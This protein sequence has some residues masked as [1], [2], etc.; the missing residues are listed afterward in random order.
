[1]KWFRVWSDMANDP[2]WRTI[3]RVSGQRIGDVMAVYLH[4]LTL[5]SNAEERGLISGWNDEDIASALDIEAGQVTAIFEAMQGRVLDDMRLTG[6]EK[7]QPLREDSSTD[8]VRQYRQKKK[9][10]SLPVSEEPVTQNETDETQC[11]APVT[12]CNARV[13]KKRIDILSGK[14]DTAP[15]Q[16]EEKEVLAYLNQKT[17]RNYQPVKANLSL[18]TGRLKEGYST[19]DMILVIDDKC[20]AWLG[21]EKMREYLRPKTLF[22]ATNFS[23]YVA[24]TGQSPNP[25]KPWELP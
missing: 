25:K 1:M 17:G 9:Q 10:E 16:N 13:D 7:R 4:M 15:S 2:K 5:A 6:W 18:I 21:D 20:Q 23:Q 24:G 8:R 3:A 14:P 19:D 12:Q 22:N 11:N